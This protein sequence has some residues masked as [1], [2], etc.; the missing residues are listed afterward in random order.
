VWGG[1]AARL[2]LPL[3]L[4]ACPRNILQLPP[5]P[6]LAAALVLWV[7]AQAAVVQAQAI[8]G[9]RCF[10]P[11]RCQPVRYDYAR[12]ASAA[13][14]ASAGWPAGDAEAPPGSA[15]GHRECV[16]CSE[17]VPW[18]APGAR[19]TARM[20]TPCGHFFHTPC[21]SRWL[22]IKLE[23]PTCRGPLPLP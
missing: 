15:P 19:P 1:S 14:R 13:E 11:Q 5:R 9:A 7:L 6:G 22:A 10:L 2:A 8:W 23:C 16:I 3:Y 20:A 21:L 17:L 12:P 18:E 4:L